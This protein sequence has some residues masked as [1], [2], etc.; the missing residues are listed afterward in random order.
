MDPVVEV[1]RSPVQ[2]EQAALLLEGGRLVIDHL[3][4]EVASTLGL[5][6][7]VSEETFV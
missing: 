1:A 6:V 3:E 2:V 7:E 4:E 5:V